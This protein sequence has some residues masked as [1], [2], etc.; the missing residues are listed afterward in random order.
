MDGNSS[1]K[2]DGRFEALQATIKSQY[3]TL[4]RRLKTLAA[5]AVAHPED[6]AL[7]TLA[8]LAEAADSHPSTFVRLSKQLGFSGFSEMQA[9]YR[10][11]LR[12]TLN[13]YKGRLQAVQPEGN[14]DVLD[15]VIDT[16][17]LSLAQMR[18][19]FHDDQWTDMLDALA[20]ADTIWLMAAGRSAVVMDYAHYLMTNMGIISRRVSPYP[21]VGARELE[22]FG[23]NDKLIAMSFRPYN[24]HVAQ[25]VKLAHMKN[26]QTYTITDTQISPLFGETSLLVKENDYVG[27]RSMSAATALIQA[28]TIELGKRRVALGKG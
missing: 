11:N 9:I 10:T 12:G 6:M 2:L 20:G 26:L 4:P 24:E 13:S 21:S 8:E 25:L 27:F 7:L 5:F 1:T 3:E 17:H 16:A 18:D 15:A 23:P 19:S 14:G 28:M 22:L